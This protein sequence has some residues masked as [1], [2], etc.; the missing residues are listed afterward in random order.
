MKADIANIEACILRV[1]RYISTEVYGG[2]IA[3]P[4]KVCFG[5]TDKLRLEK[6][7]I[8]SPRSQE[9]ETTFEL[10]VPYSWQNTEGIA[11]TLYNFMSKM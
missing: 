8:F 5:D 2:K 4:S 9:V 3:T 1:F 6:V 7:L 10:V 11:S